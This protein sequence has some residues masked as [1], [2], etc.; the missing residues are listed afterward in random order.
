[1]GRRERGGRGQGER[2]DSM[3]FDNQCVCVCVCACDGRKVRPPGGPSVL[4]W[5]QE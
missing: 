4:S 5:R 3:A 2:K 1:M